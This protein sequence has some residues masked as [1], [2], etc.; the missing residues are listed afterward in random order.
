MTKMTTIDAFT[1]NCQANK[2]TSVQ[3]NCKDFLSMIPYLNPP[4]M[5]SVNVFDTGQML[6]NC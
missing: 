2:G 3:L 5:N 4:T 6:V 1:C